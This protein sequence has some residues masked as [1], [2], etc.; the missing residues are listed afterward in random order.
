MHTYG[1]DRTAPNMANQIIRLTLHV[2]SGNELRLFVDIILKLHPYHR[3]LITWLLCA[4]DP[5][6]VLSSVWQR[7]GNFEHATIQTTLCL[8]YLNIYVS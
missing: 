2:S 3:H 4:Y 6:K 5:Y 8:L 1:K 7:L